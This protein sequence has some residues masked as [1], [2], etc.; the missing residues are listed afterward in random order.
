MIL[1]TANELNSLPLATL[2]TPQSN[3]EVTINLDLLLTPGRMQNL[4]FAVRRRALL[5]VPDEVY[6]V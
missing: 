4:T 5:L 1:P 6:I 2:R 3:N